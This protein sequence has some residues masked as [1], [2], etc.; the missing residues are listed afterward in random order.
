M[1]YENVLDVPRWHGS[2][3][4]DYNE[5]HM[6]CY[7]RSL[8]NAD[9][10]ST[11]HQRHGN[12]KNQTPGTWIGILVQYKWW[13]EKHIINCTICL[14][15]EQTQMK[16][17]IIHHDIMAKPWKVIGADMFNL[18]NKHYLCIIDYHSKFP[19]IKKTEDLSEGSL[20]LTCEVIFAE[21]GLPKKIMLHSG[22]NFISNQ[23]KT[24]C[25]S[26]NIQ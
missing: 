23:F 21:Y 5:G 7:T 10:I 8:L 4:W 18:N 1:R 9:T 25:K 14:T 13:H 2:D 20:I 3:W 17:K 15:F 22:G 12:G 24:F 6:C 16:D 11:P 26:L 19:I